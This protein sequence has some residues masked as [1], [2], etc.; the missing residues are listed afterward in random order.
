MPSLDGPSRERKLDEWKECI[1]RLLCRSLL[2]PEESKLTHAQTQKIESLAKTYS[3][4]CKGLDSDIKDGNSPTNKIQELIDDTPQM[5]QRPDWQSLPAEKRYFNNHL[6]RSHMLTL[7]FIKVLKEWHERCKKFALPDP[8]IPLGP[9][10]D[11]GAGSGLFSISMVMCVNTIGIPNM[12]NNEWFSIDI[13]EGRNKKLDGTGVD[14]RTLKTL[15]EYEAYEAFPDFPPHTKGGYAIATLNHVLHHV[16]DDQL[17]PFLDKVAG[18]IQQGG[19]VYITEDFI[20][21]DKVDPTKERFI[22][23]FDDLF[24]PGHTGRQRSTSDWIAILAKHGLHMEFQ[25]NDIV[26]NNLAG[27]RVKDTV[28]IAR[29]ET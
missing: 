18:Q 9:C 11:I 8:H 25:T 28:L 17:D 23:Q 6:Q 27:L 3:E 10:M 2:L 7:Q 13:P 16:P 29:K 21:T 26:Y 14:R 1:T 5:T 12:Y 19:L 22:K 24:Y 15:K 20:G 4:Y